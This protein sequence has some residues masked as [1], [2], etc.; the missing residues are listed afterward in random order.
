MADDPEP[1]DIDSDPDRPTPADLIPK[2][3]VLDDLVRLINGSEPDRRNS[4]TATL[5]FGGTVVSG[6]V[7]SFSE[8]AEIAGAQLT[9][10]SPAFGERLDLYWRELAAEQAHVASRRRDAGLPDIAVRYVHMRDVT[11]FYGGPMGTE[12]PLWRGV[13]SDVRGWDFGGYVPGEG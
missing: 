7:I 9:D 6:T 10:A 8:W 4:F 1:Y 11:V 12:R 5:D 2:D 13:M 3:W